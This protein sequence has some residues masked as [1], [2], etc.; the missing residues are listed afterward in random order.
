M[1]RDSIGATMLRKSDAVNAV[2]DNRSANPEIG[3]LIHIKQYS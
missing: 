1:T 3:S 2:V